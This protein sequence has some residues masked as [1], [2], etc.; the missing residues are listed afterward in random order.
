MAKATRRVNTAR[1]RTSPKY[2]PSRGRCRTISDIAAFDF[3][4]WAP[5]QDG[6]VF[7]PQELADTLAMWV[8]LSGALLSKSRSE[9]AFILTEK[10]AP[11]KFEELVDDVHNTAERLKDLAGLLLTRTNV[12]VESFAT[13][14]SQQRIR[15]RPLSRRKR[16]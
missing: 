5:L 3:R 9:L 15:S 2:K 4:P 7:L 6:E 12:S 16:K 14:A 13:V 8:R 1:T 10:M 11:S